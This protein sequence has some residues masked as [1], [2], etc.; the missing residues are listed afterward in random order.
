MSKQT[1]NRDKVLTFIGIAALVLLTASAW[2]PPHCPLLAKYVTGCKV[3]KIITSP[4]TKERALGIYPHQ[5]VTTQDVYFSVPSNADRSTTT[6]A[7]AYQSDQPEFGYAYLKVKEADGFVNIAL[8][9]DSLLSDLT[10]PLISDG[11]EHLY[12]HNGDYVTIQDMLEHMPD[13]SQVAVDAAM[14][15]RLNLAENTYT[16]LESLSSLAGIEYILTTY[17]PPQQDDI[18][19]LYE[20]TFNL[21]NASVSSANTLD[22]ELSFSQAPPSQNPFR[23][24]QMHVNYGHP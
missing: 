8:L 17:A 5:D 10:W 21:S 13:K 19:N 22:W 15:K 7:F 1:I 4:S 14:A 9:Y 2:I 23:L 11:T 18:W 6:L 24:G 16:P 20:Q 3:G 12:Q